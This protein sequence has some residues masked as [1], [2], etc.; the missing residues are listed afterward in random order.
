MM[1][2]EM[3]TLIFQTLLMMG[4][5]YSKATGNEKLGNEIQDFA[6]KFGIKAKVIKLSEQEEGRKPFKL[7]M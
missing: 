7:E 4:E 2:H 1:H 5:T 6:E 3:N